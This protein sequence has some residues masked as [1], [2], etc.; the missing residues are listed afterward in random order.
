[1]GWISWIL[2][3]FVAGALARWLMPGEDKMG[4]L[5][6]IGLGV[7]GAFLGGYIGAFAGVGSVTGFNIGTI[8]TA[9]VGA[10]ILLFAYN[11]IIL[12]K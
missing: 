8:V 5:L 6:T 2:L 9:T 3:G 11:K 1:M 4:W 7:A 12:K 10:F